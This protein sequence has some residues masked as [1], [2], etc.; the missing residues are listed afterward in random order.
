MSDLFPDM[1]GLEIAPE[2]RSWEPI[3]AGTYD[4]RATHAEYGVSKAGSP[5]LIVDWEVT[6]GEHA[7]KTARCWTVFKFRTGIN[8]ALVNHLDAVGLWPDTK[9]GRVK[10]LGVDREVTFNA[11]LEKIIG[12]D[13]EIDIEVQEGR[14]RVDEDGQRIPEFDENGEVQEDADGN[15]IWSR[16]PDRSMIKNVRFPAPK[17]PAKK[18]RALTI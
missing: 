16:W 17:K 10:A 14:I 9:D 18:K 12:R 8:R 6:Q 7:G 5:M 1:S 2:V 3:P 11:L 13:A 4:A 15:I